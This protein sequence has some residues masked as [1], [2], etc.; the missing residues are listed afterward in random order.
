MKKI[1]TEKLLEHADE[2]L[3]LSEREI[4]ASSLG[5]NDRWRDN[6][7]MAMII[8]NQKTNEKLVFVTQILAVTTI[9]LSI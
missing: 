1:I 2:I 3:N 6:Y 4:M 9:M 7:Q 8:K 5:D